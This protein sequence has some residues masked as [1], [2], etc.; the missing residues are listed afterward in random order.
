MTQFRDNKSG[1]RS[2]EDVQRLSELFPDAAFFACSDIECETFTDRST[3]SRPNRISGA[4]WPY[5]SMHSAQV[6]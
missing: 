1:S 4:S 2:N 6:N 5:R 3:I